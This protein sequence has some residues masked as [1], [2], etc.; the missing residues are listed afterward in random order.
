[1]PRYFVFF[2]IPFAFVINNL[3]SSEET[4]LIQDG[5]EFAKKKH[6]IPPFPPSSPSE[7]RVDLKNPIYENG[8]LYTQQ[9]GVVHTQDIRI[10]A[11][12]IQYIH[13]M[14]KGTFVHRI[15]AQQDLLVQ[16]KRRVY[17][18]DKLEFDFVTQTGVIYNGKTF[19][20][21]WYIGGDK[22]ELKKEGNYVIENAYITTCED[23]HGSWDLFAN[24]IEVL[25]KSL[26][27][28]EQVYF[29]FFKIP[30]LW[31]P[32]FKINLKKFSKPVV[33]YK[34]SW[35]KNGPRVSLRYQLY[36]WKDFAFFLRGDWR[37]KRGLGVAFETDYLPTHKRTIFLTRNYVATDSLENDL[38]IKRR[39]R[40]Q[41]EGRVKTYSSKT[42]GHITW[43]KYNDINM[44]SDFPSEDFEVNSA[45]KTQ[46]SIRHQ[47][48]NLIAILFARP[49]INSFNTLKQDLPLLYGTVRP[50][51]L[52][53]SGLI[54]ENWSKA[55]YIDLAYSNDLSLSLPHLYSIRLE[56]QNKIY[57]PFLLSPLTFTP[58]VGII[59]IYY[60]RSP[61]NQPVGMGL[62]SYGVVAHLHFYRHFQTYKHVIEPYAD[63]QGL[64]S[65]T[66]NNN[67][68]FIFS[69]Q[70]GYHRLNLLRLGFRNFLFVREKQKYSPC[71][72]SDLWGNAFFGDSNQS[73]FIP[74]MYLTLH[75][76]LPTCEIIN[77]NAW[78]FCHQTIDFANI[79]TLWTFNEDFAIS[80]ELRYRSKYDWR[81]SD[82]DNFIL[83]ITRTESELL[84]SSIS[85]R[86]VTLLTHIFFRITPFWSAQIKSHSGWNRINELPYNE[87]NIDLFT[88][89]T[90][91]WKA[92]LTYQKTQRDQRIT[93]SITLIKK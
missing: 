8:L 45:N 52:G 53:T 46:T 32:S 1:M 10:Q 89:I 11:R 58:Y 39:Y 38:K 54:T 25:D 48:N 87:F 63:F 86:R 92:R 21:P 30:T 72:Y 6:S 28:A 59:G 34:A 74:K 26:I 20:A 60:S 17:V 75:W 62:I 24:R 69:I 5:I 84:R 7:W 9:G 82:H 88:Y 65:P 93:G 35:D 12:T 22:I 49:R 50:L 42:Q 47:E 90:Q 76:N 66:I 14:E 81:K 43:D 57:R 15:E 55:A 61:I 44:P 40:I 23:K 64:T 91:S 33:R 71:F 41:G 68:H 27:N 2:I 70:D 51:C 36:S 31:L 79:R 18:G 29:R 56:T 3:L 19:V 85:D 83:D 73:Q 67:Q 77:T 16:Y 80:L 13:R 4:L 78:N 37:M